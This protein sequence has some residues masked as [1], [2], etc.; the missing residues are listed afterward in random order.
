MPGG[1][2]LWLLGSSGWSADASAQL[3]LPYAFAHFINPE[4]TRRAIEYY[5]SHFKPSKYLDAPRVLVAIGAVAAETQ[6]E[7]DLMYSSYRMRR[8]MRDRGD[9]GPI[10]SPEE[11][12]E[13]LKDYKERPDDREQG[14][15][16][17]VI[18]GTVADVHEQLSGMAEQL[19]VDEL[20]LISVVH[21]HQARL[22][23]YELLAEAFG[24]Q[25]RTELGA[26]QATS[27]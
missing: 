8:I 4:P 24:I 26:R 19:S 25:P 20:M 7:A 9:R 11:S 14:E 2:E 27:V 13:Q 15:W 10:P 6:E 23:S 5:R 16:P 22:R 12:L 3:G 1:P 21:S 18:H 17:R